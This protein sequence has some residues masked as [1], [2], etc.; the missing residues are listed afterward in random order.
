[1]SLKRNVVYLTVE[2]AVHT[3]GG[4]LSMLLVARVLGTSALAD[5]GFAISLTAFF[6]PVLDLG[7][8]NRTIKSVASGS[9]AAETV[10]PVFSYKVSISLFVLAAMVGVGWIWGGPRVS[11]V[12]VLIG[13]STISM[14]IGDCAN[15]AFKGLQ[16]SQLSCA[17][18]SGLNVLLVGSMVTV[19]YLGAG[20]V[21]VAACYAASRTAYAL[22]A[23]WLVHRVGPGRLRFQ[24][25]LDRE[26]LW[27]GVLHLPGIYYLF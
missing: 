14:S 13:L 10:A 11:P 23:L 19:L 22:V 25:G 7:L 2:K 5:Y 4:L 16:T 18:V 17:L 3:L 15:A 6:I 1:M 12:V 21:A 26:M 8:N 9:D 20:L 24:L 27:S